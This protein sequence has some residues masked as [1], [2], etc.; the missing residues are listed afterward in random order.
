M[1]FFLSSP[2]PKRIQLKINLMTVSIISK[3]LFIFS[4]NELCTYSMFSFL[5]DNSVRDCVIHYGN[6]VEPFWYDSV[7]NFLQLISGIY[8][9]IM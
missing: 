5:Y 4:L 1:K 9:E 7:G 2:V 8:Y 3:E 6:A